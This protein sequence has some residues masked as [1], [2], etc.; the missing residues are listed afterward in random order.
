M[1]LTPD[2]PE[3]KRSSPLRKVAAVRD[4]PS[5]AIPERVP[6]QPSYPRIRPPPGVRKPDETLLP[7]ASPL[8]SQDIT[9]RNA[10]RSINSWLS[11]L[12]DLDTNVMFQFPEKLGPV[13]FNPANS[14]ASWAPKS[15]MAYWSLTPRRIVLILAGC[16]AIWGLNS[17]WSLTSRHGVC[18]NS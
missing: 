14:Q 13:P 5:L 16:L 17:F 7:Q 4:L 1:A 2:L 8:L 10:T 12:P 18:A 9:G 11:E 3:S 6:N 15:R